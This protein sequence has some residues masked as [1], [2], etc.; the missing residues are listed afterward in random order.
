MRIFQKELYKIYARRKFILVVLLFIGV[1]AALIFTST[2]SPIVRPKDYKKAYTH[3]G[4]LPASEQPGYI[5]DCYYAV[6]GDN[7]ST[8]TEV[9]AAGEYAYFLYQELYGQ[10]EQIEGYT[11]YLQDIQNR[12]Q[13]AGNISIFNNKDPFSVR[14]ANKTVKAFQPL[15]GNVLQFT[16]TH[17]FVEATGF[18]A[19]DFFMV[20]LIFFVVVLLVV[21]EK[22]KGLFALVK[23]LSHGRAHLMCAK[24]G[25]LFFSALLFTL[26]FW[27][28]N[29]L[30]TTFKYGALDLGVRLQSVG[31]YAGSALNV[32]L[33]QYWLL[34]LVSKMALYFLIGLIFFYF[35][36]ISKSVVMLYVQ[37]VLLFLVSLVLYWTVDG[38]SAF[39]LLKYMNLVNFVQVTPIY[40]YYF[41]LNIFSVPVNI[42]TVFAVSCTL[43]CIVIFFLNLYIFKSQDSALTLKASPLLGKGQ[44]KRCHTSLLYHEAYKL[45]VVQKTFWILILF[46]C[47]QGYLFMQRTPYIGESERYYKNYMAIFGGEVTNKTREMIAKEEKRLASFAH[48]RDEAEQNFAQGKISLQEYE[49]ARKLA[50]DNTKGQEAFTRVLEHLAYVE[51]QGAKTGEVP[52]MVYETGYEMLTGNSYSGY[53]DDMKNTAV[54]LVVMIAAFAA[55]FGTEYSTGM[56][57]MISCYKLGRANTVKAK[58]RAAFPLYTAFFAVGYLTDFIGVYSQYGLPY[59]NAKLGAISALAGFPADLKLWQYLGLLYVC[60]YVVFCCILLLIFLVSAFFK[61]TGTTL[62]VLSIVLVIPAFLHI[63]GLRWVDYFSLN[64]FIS[65]NILLN[66]LKGGGCA[67]LLLVSGVAGVFS[68]MRLLRVYGVDS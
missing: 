19:T 5:R 18:L 50:E 40:Q 12:A 15:E 30:L 64:A 58:L 54:V 59:E 25:V 44:M 31:G 65:G 47:L 67:I 13:N 45:L 6:S 53:E 66:S 17:T 32:T 68:Y 11:D 56:I 26:L 2:S 33:L 4:S 23:P 1:N 37:S 10:L 55:F 20:A 60:R 21:Q 29:L 49:S 16:N 38:N 57:H 24:M 42:V 52:W 34:F 62:L 36:L 7:G 41:N 9:E 51:G 28:G 8:E 61:D 35:A 3:I 46:L 39:Q 43:F 48:I 63:I 14:N 27:G 22:E